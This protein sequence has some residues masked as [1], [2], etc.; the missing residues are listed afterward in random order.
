MKANELTTIRT[1]QPGDRVRVYARP[2]T[3]SGLEGSATL[4]EEYRPDEGD[5]FA[6]FRVHF[7]GDP[8]EC[9]YLRTVRAID[10]L[11]KAKG[12]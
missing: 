3:G 2:L 9:E 11:S 7:D 1:L 5:G 6:M 12:A 4:L 8:R 10:R